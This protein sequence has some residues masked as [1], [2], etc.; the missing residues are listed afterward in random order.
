MGYQTGPNLE[1]FTYSK[2][3]IDTMLRSLQLGS[4]AIPNLSLGPGGGAFN[5]TGT[6]SYRTFNEMALI[7][8][9][10]WQRWC[11]PRV[12]DGGIDFTAIKGGRGIFW[13]S[14]Y[15]ATVGTSP[16][17]QVFGVAITHNGSGWFPQPIVKPTGTTAPNQLNGAM[18]CSS[19]LEIRTGDTIW[20][21]VTTGPVVRSI[22]E[23]Y[24]D[25]ILLA[26]DI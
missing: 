16:V 12:G 22:A 15:A 3:E 8:G 26:E 6:T 1:D 5:T 19:V 25:I 10:N 24:L 7:T 18:S 2:A 20:G 23:Y 17:I 14:A 21:G 9:F 13:V 4:Y 11:T